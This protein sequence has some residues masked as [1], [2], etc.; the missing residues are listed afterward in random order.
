MSESQ[1]A[2]DIAGEQQPIEFIGSARER[3][4]V[5]APAVTLPVADAI[6]A[7]WHELRNDATVVLD[8]DP[9]VYRLGYGDEASLNRLTETAAL[10]D[11]AIRRQPG[12]RLGIVIADARTLIYSPTPRLIEAGPNT[13]G[14]A[15]ALYIGAP[16]AALERDIDASGGR[17]RV[18]G[19]TLQ[20]G[21][22]TRIRR[23]L[24]DNPPQKFDIARRMTV[25]NAYFEF[26]EFELTGVHIERKRVPI[27]AHLLGVADQK[28]REQI[29]SHFQV[30]PDGSKLSGEALRHD[31]DLIARRFLCVI[32]NFGTVVRRSDKP[33]FKEAVEALKKSVEVFRQKL[34]AEL[35][36]SMDKSRRELVKALLPGVQRHPPKQWRFSDGR[37]PDKEACRV[38]IEQE[39]EQAFG[40]AERVLSGMD[41]T[42]RFKGVTYEML[43]DDEFLKAAEKVRLDVKRLHEEFDA[44]KAAPAVSQ[45]G[46]LP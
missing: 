13:P 3:L 44:A 9:E 17:P 24:A 45:T 32:P 11:V 4:V 30:V 28:T 35:Q 1:F 15:N 31:R 19:G 2:I 38:Y 34:Q 16:P 6:C 18:G 12:L 20:E 21:D 36:Q 10:M 39:L 41:V 29:R 8:S 42:L 46:G 40:S 25:F 22:L 14:S 37:K 7:K 27:P 43:K 23:D 33:A 5:I 26:V